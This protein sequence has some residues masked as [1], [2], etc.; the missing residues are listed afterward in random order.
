MKPTL[1]MDG[2]NLRRLAEE[3]DQAGYT[4]IY[5]DEMSFGAYKDGKLKKIV[6]VKWGGIKVP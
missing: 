1:V 3:L 5:N 6:R 4:I 2:T